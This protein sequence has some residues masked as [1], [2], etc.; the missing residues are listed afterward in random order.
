LLPHLKSIL[1]EMFKIIQ[2]CFTLI[3]KNRP[4]AH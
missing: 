3:L 1:K 4:T 2:K